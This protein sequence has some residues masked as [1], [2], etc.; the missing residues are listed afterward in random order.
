MFS[1][2]NQSRLELHTSMSI[3]LYL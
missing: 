2:M 3:E 1:A